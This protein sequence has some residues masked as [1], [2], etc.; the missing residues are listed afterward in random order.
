MQASDFIA[1]HKKYQDIIVGLEHQIE[2]AKRKMK[3]IAE[4][5]SLLE[6]EGILGQSEILEK[7]LLVLSDRYSNMTMKQAIEDILHG[8]QKKSAEQIYDELMKNGFKSESKNLKRDL[9]T[10][11]YA[12][13][14]NDILI[15]VKE[16]GLKRY[17]LTKNIER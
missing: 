1:L 9:F 5:I 11:L 14:K 16:G 6:K 4:A 10:R 8:G 12:L 7:Q 17:T 2:D 3:V 13:T 15:S